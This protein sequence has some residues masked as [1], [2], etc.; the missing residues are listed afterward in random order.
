ML[1]TISKTFQSSLQQNRYRL[2]DPIEPVVS[3]HQVSV[4]DGRIGRVEAAGIIHRP[5]SIVEAAGIIHR[6]AS[7]EA[8]KAAK[9]GTDRGISPE[10][11]RSLSRVHDSDWKKGSKML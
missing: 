8:A 1:D 10:R 9:A 11:L 6:P 5:A 4:G 2:W 7:D 3:S